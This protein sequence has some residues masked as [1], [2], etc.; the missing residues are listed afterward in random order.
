MRCDDSMDGRDSTCSG[1]LPVM[2]TIVRSTGGGCGRGSA[3]CAPSR[4][5]Y[6]P[7]KTQSNNF[8]EAM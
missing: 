2:R 5:V 4:F 1:A 3:P 8:T 7:V 6:R